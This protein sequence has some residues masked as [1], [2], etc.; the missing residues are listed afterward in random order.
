MNA[1][2]PDI[3]DHDGQGGRSRR[4]RGRRRWSSATTAPEAFSRGRQPVRAAWW[5]WARGQSQAI[6]ADGGRL[7]EAPASAPRY[8][9]VPVVAAPFGL[10]LGGGAE[11]MLGCQAVRAAAELYVGLRRGRRRADPGRRRLHGDGGARVGPRAR[12]SA[13]RPA[14]AGARRRSRRWRWRK[15]A[16]SAEEARDLGYLRHADSISMAR[17]TLIADA[18]QLALGLARAGYRPPPPR[19]IR[20]IGETGAATLQTALHNLVGAHRISEH[21]AKV[22]GQAGPRPVAAATSRPGAAVSEQHMLDLER[23][24]FLSL[25]GEPKTRDRIQHMLS[26]GKPLRN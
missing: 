7:P 8:A 24:A 6:D 14:A 18:K 23:E 16:T 17:E 13:V 2:D 3:V 10:A 20:V 4:A 15:V 9:R 19:R 12:R 5:R 22:G 21:D 11:V 1:I 26:T 25:C